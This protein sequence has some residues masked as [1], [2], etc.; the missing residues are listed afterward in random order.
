MAFD[1][2]ML[3]AVI[4]EINE[5]AA[6]AR[7]DKIHQ[8]AMDEVVLILHGRTGSLR[9]SVNGGANNPK[10][11]FTQIIKENPP[12]P[13]MFCVL[14]RKHLLGARFVSATQLGANAE[15]LT[16]FGFERAAEL[17]FSA[18]D[19]MGFVSDKYL[20]AEIMGKYS[21]I[22]LLDENRK[23]L[24]VLRAVDFTTS[25]LRQVL[26]G[27][28]YELPPSQNKKNPLTEDSEGFSLSLRQFGAQRP[29]SRFI[30][31]TYMGIS[32]LVAREIVHR[33]AGDADIPAGEVSPRR[34]WEEF[35]GVMTQIR[36]AAYAP[37]LISDEAG[38]PVDFCFTAIGQYGTGNSV[39]L[40]VCADFCE[41]LDLFYAGR[42]NNQR[43]RQRA[44]DIIRLLTSARA[45]LERK[46]ELQQTELSACA[47]CEKYKRWGD[48]ITANLHRLKKGQSQALVT[49]YYSEGLEEVTLPLDPR[50][51]PAQNAQKMYKKYSKAKTA[52]I[53]LAE[54]MALARAELDY[55]GSVLDSVTRTESE[56]DLAEIR[57]ELFSSG[58]A[59]KMK[60]YHTAKKS[61]PKPAE[62]R[63][64][65]GYRVLCGKN[66]LQNDYITFRLAAK[67]DLWFHVQNRPG[68]HVVMLCGEEE[69]SALDYT[70]AAK[71]AAYYSSAAD[72][73]TAPVDYTRVKNI[74]KPPG[75]KP[76]YVTYSTHYTA[77]VA[78]D[79]ETVSRLKIR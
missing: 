27:M 63:T 1:S 14:L 72:A 12:A 60:N 70:Q 11:G 67:S 22:I 30:L 45:R 44:A 78:L 55:I 65:G 68:S 37:T 57:E 5:K 48:L 76:G 36:T 75:S 64:D 33:A 15:A 66:N 31:D 54:Q 24:S 58:Y 16:P 26:P 17:K 13:P 49:D 21:N 73:P 52:Q 35:D 77:F 71:I 39:R 62:F 51:T 50:L 40:R 18:R 74:K 10:L 56:S 2:G 29:A 20:I 53:T 61:A 7:V 28:R 69:P 6:G 59:S 4:H 79:P 42:E 46:L 43:I 19:E 8:P 23:I 32:S 41:L 3:T 47:D 34:F 25:R 38:A 9:L